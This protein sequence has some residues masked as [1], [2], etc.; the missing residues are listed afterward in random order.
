MPL[1][2][3]LAHLTEKANQ[4]LRNMDQMLAEANKII[5]ENGARIVHA[6]V[7]LGEYDV[8]TIMEA[9][10]QKAAAKIGAL[11]A[12]QGSFRAE[13]LPAIPMEEFIKTI[14]SNQ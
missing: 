3:R 14:K 9:P 7:I 10:D 11:I 8:L 13:T 4:N 1:F 5:E 2:I 12:T 6:Y